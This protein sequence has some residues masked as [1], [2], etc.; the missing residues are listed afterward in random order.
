MATKGYVDALLNALPDD[1]KNAVIQ[2]F[3]YVLDNLA[4]GQPDSGKRATNFRWYRFDATTSSVANTEFSIH[5]G[6]G[7]MPLLCWPVMFLDSSGGRV[8][9]LTVTRPA[10]VQRIYLSSPDTSASVSMMVEF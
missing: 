10:D 2:A 5:H 9:R 3:R 6:Q 7:L 8:V 1:A 4:I